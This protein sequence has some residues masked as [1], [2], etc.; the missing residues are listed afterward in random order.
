[1]RP[2]KKRLMRSGRGVY[3]ATLVFVALI[4]AWMGY[5]HGGYYVDTW[6]VAA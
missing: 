6:A 3:S 5:A 1:M 4:P 2:V